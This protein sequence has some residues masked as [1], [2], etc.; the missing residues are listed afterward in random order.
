MNT[1]GGGGN[2]TN[3]GQVQL[4]P[5][6]VEEAKQLTYSKMKQYKR[7]RLFANDMSRMDNLC[8]ILKKNRNNDD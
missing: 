2:V 3:A 7:D 8:S 5:A 1:R 4:T 6:Q